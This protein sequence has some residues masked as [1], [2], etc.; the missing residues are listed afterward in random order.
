MRQ[1]KL[2]LQLGKTVTQ[3]QQGRE[4]PLGTGRP[5]EDT[6]PPAGELAPT[7]SAH[8]ILTPIGEGSCGL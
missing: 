6:F 1:D 5:M 7:Y 4:I 3:A 8:P 2:V